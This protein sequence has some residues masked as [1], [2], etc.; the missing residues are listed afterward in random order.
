MEAQMRKVLNFSA[1]LIILFRFLSTA[2]AQETITPEDAAKFT[3]ESKTVCGTVASAHYAAKVKGQPTSINLDKPYPNQVFTV[4]IW[5]SDRGKF[6][7]PP[8][9]LYSGKEICVMGMIQSYQGK[10]EIIVKEPG[11]IKAK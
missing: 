11:Q 4:L 10:A 3:G 1:L 7:K 9:T 5:G 2:I 8:E 6:E